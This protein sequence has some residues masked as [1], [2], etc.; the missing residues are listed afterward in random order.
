MRHLVLRFMPSDRVRFR[1]DGRAEGMGEVLA[2]GADGRR[3]HT[4]LRF[5]QARVDRGLSAVARSCIGQPAAQGD[6]RFFNPG[7]GRIVVVPA[8]GLDLFEHVEIGEVTE[9]FFDE[10]G[11]QIGIEGIGGEVVLE[12]VEDREAVGIE[13][14]AER[15][16][17]PGSG[18]H[19]VSSV[20]VHSSS[21]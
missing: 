5:R 18:I 21:C 13:R 8:E 17:H 12:V 9:Q 19:G 15:F 1:I 10:A 4:G 16:E 14:F 7:Q 2:T 6:A 20:A 3:D 11:V